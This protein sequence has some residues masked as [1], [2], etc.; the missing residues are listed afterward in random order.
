[1]KKIFIVMLTLF[2]L[3]ACAKVE[4]PKVEEQPKTA[5][6]AGGWTLNPNLPD[7]ND[8]YF[9]RATSTLTGVEY[10]PLL[11][12]GD[13]PSADTNYAYLAYG[14]TVSANPKTEFKVLIIHGDSQNS[15]ANQVLNIADFNLPDYVDNEGST[16]PDGLMG[17]W[18]DNTELPNFLDE[19][20]NELFE[21]AF[22]G[23][24]GVGYK[25]VTLLGTQVVAGTNYA[26]LAIGTSV[27][28]EPISHLYV[29]NIFE[30]LQGNV[31]L[32]NI[33]GIDLSSFNK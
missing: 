28:A 20:T 15:E 21:K 4:E 17:G 32:N 24:A 2:V 3:C 31:T 16:T 11:V 13:Q 9:S 7:I 23:F 27:T 29:V 12:L 5:E 10:R 19:K 33:C 22:E 1:M 6:I 25:P 26:I 14:T 8:A 30:D 18:K